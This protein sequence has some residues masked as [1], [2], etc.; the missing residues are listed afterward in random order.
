MSFANHPCVMAGNQPFLRDNWI[1]SFL[2][3][4]LERRNDATFLGV[5]I[6][7]AVNLWSK[8]MFKGCFFPEN[9]ENNKMKF[10]SWE[11]GSL[12]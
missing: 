12:R 11:T 5:Y 9:F 8:L 6:S 3:S 10:L 1:I 4:L 2:T 7:N